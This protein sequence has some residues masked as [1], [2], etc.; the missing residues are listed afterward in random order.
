MTFG[1]IC[2]VQLPLQAPNSQSRPKMLNFLNGA[3]DE[4]RTRDLLLGKQTL[5]QLSYTRMSLVLY[6][7]DRTGEPSRP[8]QVGGAGF[9]L[10]EGANVVVGAQPGFHVF[11]VLAVVEGN[12]WCQA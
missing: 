6:H 10:A 9:G 4:S 2:E 12:L 1:K 5:Y 11:A 3:G 7:R 8:W